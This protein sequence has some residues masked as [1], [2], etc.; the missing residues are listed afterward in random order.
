MCFLKNSEDFAP[1]QYAAR[2]RS[3]RENQP[4][5]GGAFQPTVAQ[6][7]FTAFGQGCYSVALEA[8]KQPTWG[9]HHNRLV[10]LKCLQ[11]LL[12]ESRKFQESQE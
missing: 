9:H 1:I 5:G 8:A 7:D 11:E 3:S 10:Q 2:S 12:K 6:A 4:L